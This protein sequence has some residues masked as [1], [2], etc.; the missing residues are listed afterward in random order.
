MLTKVSQTAAE[1]VEPNPALEAIR[2]KYHLP[3]LAAARFGVDGAEQFNASAVGVRK[4]GDPAGLTTH[5]KFHLGSLTKAMTATLVAILI[6]EPANNLTWNTTVHEAL[7]HLDMLPFYAN[8][9]LA[10]LG[11]HRSGINDTAFTLAETPLMLDLLNKTYSPV[12]SRRL[13][14]ERAF[15]YPP[16]TPPGQTY[17]YSNLGYMLLGHLLDTHHPRGGWEDLIRCK[18]WTPL[19][20]TGCGLGPVPQGPNGEPENPWPHAPPGPNATDP[21]PVPWDTDNPPAL[22][23]AATVHC[24]IESYGR[25]L[26]L[27]LDA[28]L[29]L[30]DGPRLLPREA[31]DV[32]HTPYRVLA[33]APLVGGTG[34]VYTPGAWVLVVPAGDPD[35]TFLLHD[36]S[37]TVNYAWATLAPKTREAFFIATNVGQAEAAMD[38]VAAGLFSRSLGV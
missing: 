5:D 20:M 30:V 32:L 9:T 8:L 16:A 17:R 12:K 7:P 33:G 36:G 10:M 34:D 19:G 38:E 22:G 24:T 2:A 3:G 29:G 18:L 15:R 31:F 21:T 37:N 13:V 35:N 1:D 27:H 4:L 14:A 11:S 26:R 28:M 25:F 6:N 23:P